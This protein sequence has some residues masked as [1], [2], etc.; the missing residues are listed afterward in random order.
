[1]NG[2]N[3]NALIRKGNKGKKRCVQDTEKKV[4]GLK[5]EREDVSDFFSLVVKSTV[6]QC[7]VA[8]RR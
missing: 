8:S 7:P 1:M 5:K 4:H 3:Q 2:P 6:E